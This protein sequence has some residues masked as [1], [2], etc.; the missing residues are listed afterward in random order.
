M[1]PNKLVGLKYAGIFKVTKV[2]T[3]PN[4]GEVKEVFCEYLEDCKE[5]PKAFLNW[6]SVK[7]SV[8]CEV[9]LYDLLFTEYDP[10]KRGDEWLSALN[11]NSLTIVKNAKMN[12]NLLGSKI[13]DRF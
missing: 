4:S 13:L 9:R 10:N 11:K 6:V 8:N 12:K 7:E 2:T 3:D 5:K 1:A